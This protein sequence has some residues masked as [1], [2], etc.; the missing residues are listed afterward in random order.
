MTATQVFGHRAGH[1]AARRATQSRTITFPETDSK[2]IKSEQ[3]RAWGEDVV[4]A[5][6]VIESRVKGTMGEYAGVLRTK[7][8]LKKARSILDTCQT[9]L[10]AL[11]FIGAGDSR[12]YCRVRDMAL[13][14]HLVVQSALAR[15]KSKG[16]HYRQ[17]DKKAPI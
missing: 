8:G 16:S 9:Q 6:G 3:P 7:K 1:F 13:T 11:G 15:G 17:D 12:E 2:Q 14:A 4:E 10:G 5:L